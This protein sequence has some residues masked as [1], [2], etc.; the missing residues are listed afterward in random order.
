MVCPGLPPH[1]Q[2]SDQINFTGKTL[3]QVKT[4]LLGWQK[5]EMKKNISQKEVLCQKIIFGW[6]LFLVINF[7]GIKNSDQEF[8]W[9]Y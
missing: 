6:N 1:Q 9:S 7:F 4:N 3:F 8:F 2:K 5:F